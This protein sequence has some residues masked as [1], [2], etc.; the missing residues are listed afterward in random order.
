MAGEVMTFTERRDGDYDIIKVVWTTS[1][2]TGAVSGTTTR[3]YTGKFIGLITN[4]DNTDVP[5]DN[6]T[7][8][9][10]DQNG[11]DLLLGATTANRD[12]T[13]TEYIGESSMAL[14]VNSKLTFNVSAAGNSKKGIIYL[15]ISRD[16]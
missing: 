4:P 16:I 1:S 12:Q 2:T 6:Y 8:T 15:T 5:S 11:E 10:T 14:V 13:N 9:V 7:I 3:F